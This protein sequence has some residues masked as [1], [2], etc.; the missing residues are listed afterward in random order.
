MCSQRKSSTGKLTQEVY[1]RSLIDTL[2]NKQRKQSKKEKK[3]QANKETNKQKAR[4]CRPGCAPRRETAC[5]R[6]FRPR[7][8]LPPVNT[9][10]F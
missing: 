9:A 1:L 5:R 7:P 6:S 8:S 3:K 10:P 4:T 2:M